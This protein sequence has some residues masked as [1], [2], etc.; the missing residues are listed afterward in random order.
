MAPEAREKKVALRSGLFG[1]TYVF[2][3]FGLS[4]AF[5]VNA[6]LRRWD[7]AVE[8]L[9]EIFTARADNASPGEAHILLELAR[10]TSGIARLI[11]KDIPSLMERLWTGSPYHLKL[12]LLE[13]AGHCWQADE[14][15]RQA[16]VQALEEIGPIDNIMLSTQWIESMEQLGALEADAERELDSLRTEIPAIL[17]QP[18]DPDQQRH[19][20]SFY[21]RRFDHPLSSAYCTV[22]DELDPAMQLQV[23]AMAAEVAEL[24]TFFAGPLIVDLA[25]AGEGLAMSP[26]RRWAILPAP[27]SMMPQDALANFLMAHII[28]AR[29]RL[30][31][32]IQPAPAPA[33]A[34]GQALMAC[35]DALY[36]ANRSDLPD[37]DRNEGVATAW[38]DM[39][40]HP[41]AALVALAECHK[42]RQEPLHR[43]PGEGVDPHEILT[44]WE[45]TAAEFARALLAD[46]DLM[47]AWFQP[48]FFDLTTSILFA[49]EVLGGWGDASDLGRLRAMS[50]IA[51]VAEQALVQVRRLEDKLYKSTDRAT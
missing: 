6:G 26:I 36:W 41:G 35:A 14:V 1:Q 10:C 42:V 24:D 49:L 4:N 16:V 9:A 15:D 33:E 48:R 27:N 46:G 44:G 19:A 5:G 47:S 17:A 20:W 18:S 2:A 40:V 21:Y 23:L 32:P 28:L 30:E 45:P 31:Q 43:L 29:N 12:E 11:A 25:R 37:H 3:G 34:A 51:K 38:R 39:A 13:V 22:F 7:G 8:D 50:Q